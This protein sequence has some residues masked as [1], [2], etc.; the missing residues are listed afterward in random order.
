MTNSLRFGFIVLQNR[1]MPELIER[2]RQVEALGLDSLW[3]ADHLGS[4]ARPDWPWFEGWTTL[5][6]MA[7]ET[8]TIRIGTLVASITLRAPA[9]LAK[10]AVTVDHL[11]GGR[12]ELGIGAAGAELDHELLGETPWPRHERTERFREY[13]VAL[14]RLLRGAGGHEGRYYRVTDFRFQPPPLQAPRPPLTIAAWSPR[15]IRL[16]AAF[17]DAWNTMGGR[18]LD[19]EHGLAA[20]RQQSA[21]LDE[22]CAEIGR[23]PG[24]IRRSLL[25]HEFWIAEEPFASEAA[26]RDVVDRYRSAGIDEFV[27]YYPAEEWGRK[28]HV[29][30]GLFERLA[31]D[32]LPELRE[33]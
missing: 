18:G 6:A 32:V 30:P 3:V 2:W 8:T 17:G 31:V 33:R 4:A 1:P 22:A 11:S 21:L 5:A 29:E 27:F 23:D 26:F 12:L 20:V 24:T 14:D 16:A 19:A 10:E 9:L 25:L 7:R 28:T 15:N 13:V